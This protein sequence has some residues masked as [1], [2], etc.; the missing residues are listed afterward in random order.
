MNMYNFS[1]SIQNHFIEQVTYQFDFREWSTV[2]LFTKFNYN[3]LKVIC[4]FSA[5]TRID[6]NQVKAY[7]SCVDLN[8]QCV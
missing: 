5:G 6:F 4:A 7:T 8:K 2:D 3:R 1:M